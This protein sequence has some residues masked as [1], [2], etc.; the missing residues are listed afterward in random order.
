M[1]YGI[2]IS[3]YKRAKETKNDNYAVHKITKTNLKSLLM[4][5]IVSFLVSRVILVNVQNTIAPFGICFLAVM[6]D[7]KE[8]KLLIGALSGGVLGY[9]FLLNRISSVLIYIVILCSITILAYFNNRFSTK[10]K[11]ISLASV[12]FLELFVGEVIFKSWDISMAFFYSFLQMMCIVPLYFII[13][14][15]I[16][17][18]KNLKI[19]H[20]YKSEEI[21]NM[22]IVVSLIIAGTWGV[23]FKDIYLQNILAL[24]FII[25]I[26]YING[27]SIGGASGIALGTIIGMSSN[28]ILV[29]ISVL[30][31]CGLITGLFK[32]TG[33]WV[34]GCC[35]LI[36]FLIIRLYTNINV[37]FEFMEMIVALIVFLILPSKIY[38]KVLL[39]LDW[40]KKQEY[41]NSDYSKKIKEELSGRLCGYSKVLDSTASVLTNLSE[42]DKLMLK[43]KSEILIERLASRVCSNCDMNKICWSRENY[44]TYCAFLE[45]IQNYEEGKKGILPKEIERKCLK[46]TQLL[47]S[48]EQI[49]NGHIINEMERKRLAETRELLSN[50]INN[51]SSYIGTLADDF[52]QDFNLDLENERKLR[53]SFK[54]LNIGIVDLYCIKDKNGR[55]RVNV[56]LESCRGKHLC[57]KKILPLINETLDKSMCVG[58][59]SCNIDKE[60]LCNVN[61]EETPKYYVSSY[62]LS[63]NKEGNKSNGDSFFYGKLSD[64]NYVSLLSD[65]MGSGE[66]ARLESSSTVNLIREIIENGFEEKKA[67]HTVNSI[68]N[69]KFSEDERFATLDLMNLDLYS[70]DIDFMK[71]GAVASFLM[72]KNKVEVVESKTLPMGVMDKL[73]IDSFKMKIE[74]RD[75]IVMVT[76]G[77]LDINSKNTGKYEWLVEYLEKT[78]INKPEEL[79]KDILKTAKVLSGGKVKDDMSAIVIKVYNLY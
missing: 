6:T 78:Q 30:G 48:T 50:H 28:N 77:V 45:L 59:E 13:R 31:V 43:G 17:C 69:F 38:S 36:S 32:E 65:G 35:A 25:L 79:S 54:N 49:V 29:Y 21:L 10:I 64:G 8:D 74:N 3:T 19:R 26:S 16:V 76:D 11:T 23:N 53:K 73:D 51:I 47:N 7:Y 2:D 46:R 37:E 70:G 20:L 63:Y 72:R 4:V 14:K 18:I 44:Y 33:K 22:A 56:K 55:T 5:F 34:A 67:L 24:F 58:N 57:V 27:P 60:G 66:E 75:I 12:I 61:F 52:Q 68:M 42:N 1:Q 62:G 15:S 39:E 71:V 9:L 41:L 40:E